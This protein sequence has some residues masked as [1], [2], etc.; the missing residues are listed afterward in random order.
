MWFVFTT[1]WVWHMF[2]VSFT[3]IHPWFYKTW[4]TEDVE[5][6]H[7]HCLHIWTV[8]FFFWFPLHASIHAITS[9]LLHST[10]N[11][12]S[13]QRFFF[14]DFDTKGEI[15]RQKKTNEPAATE[16]AQI[17]LWWLNFSHISQFLRRTAVSQCSLKS[18]VR[19]KSESLWPNQ[20][21]DNE[22]D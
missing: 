3:S 2:S 9:H 8:L 7:N 6:F 14:S 1:T 20:S 11:I 12:W 21:C 17:E 10:V 19:H 22:Q 16:T 4:F 13:G 18:K 5:G 15:L